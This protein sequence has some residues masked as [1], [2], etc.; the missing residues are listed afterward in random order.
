MT[1]T[2]MTGAS[3]QTG[4]GMDLASSPTAAHGFISDARQNSDVPPGI[5][6][7]NKTENLA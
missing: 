7:E 4:R 5:K 1:A 3:N 2:R 6:A